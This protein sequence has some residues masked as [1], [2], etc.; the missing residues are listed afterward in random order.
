MKPRPIKA[1]AVIDTKKPRLL[2]SE[3]Y[4]DKDIVLNKGEKLIRVLISN[5]TSNKPT[6]RTRR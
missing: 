2:V 3:I 5:D 6:R 1:W 4:E